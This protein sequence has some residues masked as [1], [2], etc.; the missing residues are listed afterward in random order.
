M[1][2]L[3]GNLLINLGIVSG[4]IVSLD[5]FLSSSIKKKITAI[6]EKVWLWIEY[7]RLLNFYKNN[8]GSET[9]FIITAI[10]VPIRV[11]IFILIDNLPLLP[12]LGMLV[13]ISIIAY[14][15]NNFILLYSK[16]YNDFYTNYKR[17]ILNTDSLDIV[18]KRC[19]E[20][21]L[22]YYVSIPFFVLSILKLEIIIIL[23]GF[24]I[25]ILNGIWFTIFLWSIIVYPLKIMMA[26]VNWFIYKAL[27]YPKGPVLFISTTLTTIGSILKGINLF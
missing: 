12:V 8:P 9:V 1:K 24:P 27:S 18:V 10:L 3:L 19:T 7:K 15:S 23:F 14:V 22:N 2:D 26:A 16:K 11:F 25:I 6:F 21:N 13:V 17:Y 20:L 4:L 5:F